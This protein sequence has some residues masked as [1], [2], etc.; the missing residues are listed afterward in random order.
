MKK[1]GSG[2]TEKQICAIV[3]QVVD[4]L[5]YMHNA[6]MPICH[7]DIKAANILLN[8]R[9]E[10]KLADFGISAQISQTMLQ[11]KTQVGSPYW[12]APEVL[13]DELYDL[14]VD[15]WSVGI[16]GITV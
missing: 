1:L 14:R 15:I 13:A 5:V 4:G 3:Q 11:L 10:I 2:F 6:S 12:M 9:G 8:D 7:R 16:T